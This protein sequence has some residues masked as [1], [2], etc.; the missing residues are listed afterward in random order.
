MRL[1]KYILTQYLPLSKKLCG[2]VHLIALIKKPSSYEKVMKKN[3]YQIG[4]SDI[5]WVKNIAYPHFR[6]VS[7]HRLCISLIQTELNAH[8]IKIYLH[9]GSIFD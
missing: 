5:Y 9:I 3:M 7:E 4:I 8:E 6:D 2:N 1:D